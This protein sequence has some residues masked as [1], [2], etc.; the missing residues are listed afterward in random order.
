M[1]S[2]SESVSPFLNR[3]HY[4]RSS[5]RPLRAEEL[6]ALEKQGNVISG[7]IFTS[8]PDFMTKMVPRIRNN[9]FLNSTYICVETPVDPISLSSSSSPPVEW[10]VYGNT[11]S[12]TIIDGGSFV[13]NNAMIHGAYIGGGSAIV[14]NG[15]ISG[16]IDKLFGLA[17][18]PTLVVCEETGSRKLYMHPDM[19]LDNVTRATG[20]VEQRDEWNRKVLV[21]IEAVKGVIGRSDYTPCGTII[22][23]KSVLLKNSELANFFSTANNRITNSKVFNTLFVGNNNSVSDSVVFDS[24]LRGNTS[25]EQYSVVENSVLCPHVKISIHAKVV[26][27]I[28]GSYSGVES[29]ECISS[30]IGPFVGFHHQSLVIATY[31]PEGKGNVGYGANV[32]SNHTGKAPDQELLSGEGVFYGLASVVKFPCNFSKAPYSLIASGVVCLPQCVTMP[33]SLIGGGVSNGLNEIFPGWILSDNMFTLLR[34]EDKFR[35]RQK[36]DAVVEWEVFRPDTM[37]LVLA[38]RDALKAVKMV[39]PDAMYTESEIPGLGKNFIRESARLKAIDTYSFILRW[40]GLRGLYRKVQRLGVLA[41]SSADPSDATWPYERS[42]II[43]EGLNLNQTESLLRE[44]AQ[45]DFQIAASCT[46]SKAKDDVRGA[47]VIGPVYSE[48]HPPANTH[49]VCVKAMK[50]SRIVEDNVNSIVSKL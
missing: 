34:N 41:A 9:V 19:Q 39:S 17:E 43:G 45:L 30:L 11:I 1:N 37:A 16:S 3:I 10:G 27:S 36:P 14:D 44:F 28:I 33:F 35:T 31:W 25:I 49:S 26:H 32:G 4:I 13:R 6:H 5:S 29:G 46:S 8:V 47:K 22:G 40:Y 18:S 24:I 23:E 38:A 2:F 48:F 50:S 42:I 20:G 15:V 12:D 21:D 7:N